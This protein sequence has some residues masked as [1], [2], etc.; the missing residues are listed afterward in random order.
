MTKR[1]SLRAVAQFLKTTIANMQLEE[2]GRARVGQS[3]QAVN[4]DF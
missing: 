3:N 2:E 4:D 1:I